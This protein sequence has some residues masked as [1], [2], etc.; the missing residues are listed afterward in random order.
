MVLGKYSISSTK[1][2][3]GYS[4]SWGNGFIIDN[5]SDMLGSAM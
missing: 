3:V 1:K 2:D 5:I 4:T